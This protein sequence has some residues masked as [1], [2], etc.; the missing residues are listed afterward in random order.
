MHPMLKTLVVLLLVG[1]AG[2]AGIYYYSNQTTEAAY[3]KK[4]E[5]LSQRWTARLG[6]VQGI[7]DPQ[8]YN[9]EMSTQLKWYFSQLQEIYNHFPKQRDPDR[10]WKEI[11]KE[12]DSGRI[13]AEKKA[14]YKE[15]FDYA[16]K[17]FGVLQSG[18]YAGNPN[19]SSQSMHMDIY[20]MKPVSYQGVPRIRIDF[21]LWGAPHRI[22]SHKNQVGTTINKVVVPVTFNKMFFQFLDDKG[23]VYGEMSGSG[24][25]PTIKIEDPKRWIAE[26]PAGALLGTWWVDMFPEKAAKVVW[27]IGMTGRTDAGNPI[28]A[29]YRWT[30]DVPD[31]WKS[32]SWKEGAQQETRDQDYINHP[33]GET[34]AAKK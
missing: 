9:E 22:Q 32:G 28:D 15:F 19:G 11:Q 5:D 34:T 24:G 13:P 10:A 14:E 4:L 33:A 30:L 8:R 12:L 2:A 23:K 1:G 21:I 26:F 31:N 17:V 27:E 6:S 18:D 7:T 3:H 29:S 20:S 16:K 25:E